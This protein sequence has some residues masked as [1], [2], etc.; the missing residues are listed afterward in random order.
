[1]ADDRKKI[2]DDLVK[3]RDVLRDKKQRLQGKL[4]AARTELS[5]IEDECRKRGVPPEKLDATIEQ[6][7]VRYNKAIAELTQQITVAES[8]LAP[9]T[10]NS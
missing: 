4:E 9:F 8:N 3:R 1:M 5:A 2:L 6:L 7:G 10:E